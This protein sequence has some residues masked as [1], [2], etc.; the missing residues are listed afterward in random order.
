MPIVLLPYA[1][2]TS[3]HMYL[4]VQNLM[5]FQILPILL[6]SL[7]ASNLFVQVTEDVTHNILKWPISVPVPVTVVAVVVTLKLVYKFYVIH[8]LYNRYIEVYL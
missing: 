6:L 8:A 3:T 7:L 1:I 4:L 2:L 5:E